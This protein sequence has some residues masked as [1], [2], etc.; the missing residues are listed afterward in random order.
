MI[1]HPAALSL[2]RYCDGGLGPARAKR[3]AGH[4]AD[5]S[6]CRAVVA[7]MRQ[8]GDEARRAP[9][10]ELGERCWERIAA[11]RA[12]G[13]RAIL[14]TEDPTPI[15]RSSTWIRVAAAAIVAVT[16]G[17]VA[18]PLIR[19]AAAA[20]ASALSLEPSHPMPGALVTVHYRPSAALAEERT[21]MLYGRFVPEIAVATWN[22]EVDRPMG[23][24][25][26]TLARRP[27]G[28]Y[29]GAFRLPDS[30]VYAD[31]AVG[32]LEANHLDND[33]GRLWPLVIADL[34][35]LR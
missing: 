16:L 20:Q 10:P 4:L 28:T 7:S 13:E 2:S 22:F 11:R 5:C 27:D 17:V 35:G 29:A 3:V 15:R 34:D 26:T 21:L 24:P 23:V 25:I 33:R 18:R 32:D 19:A 14:P 31:F 9:V 1:F 6:H 12:D 30:A 8:L